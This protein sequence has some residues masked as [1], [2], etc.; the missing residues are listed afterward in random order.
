MGADP[1]ARLQEAYRRGVVNFNDL[2]DAATTK[3]KARALLMKQMDAASAAADTQAADLADAAAR[4]PDTKAALD[5][6][7]RSAAA[8]GEVR[9]SIDSAI[10]QGM[11]PDVISEIAGRSLDTARLGAAT[12]ATAQAA[13]LQ[14]LERSIATNP[15]RESLIKQ[16]NELGGY[17]PPNATDAE[18]ANHAANFI[19]RSKEEEFAVKLLLQRA[20]GAVQA[21]GNVREAEM[22]LAEVFRKDPTIA[23]ADTVRAQYGL[24]TKM[25][26]KPTPTAASD[27][28]AVFGF[29]KMMDPGSVVREGEYERA[30]NATSF[31]DKWG[32][33]AVWDRLS[34]GTLMTPEQR[35]DFIDTV[36]KAA[37]S[38]VTAAENVR[39]R[40]AQQ[41]AGWNLNPENV[42]FDVSLPASRSDSIPSPALAPNE[43]LVAEKNPKTGKRT[44]N[45]AVFVSGPDG[46]LT[47]KKGPTPGVDAPDASFDPRAD[48]IKSGSDIAVRASALP[49]F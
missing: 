26:T 18:V 32:M 4:R 12:Q 19:R 43:V 25:L 20:Q 28:A 15:Q 34:K 31:L 42:V 21:A 30:K 3:P 17:V 6:A 46:T 5:A 45:F 35:K 16:V 8:T 33:T 47:R 38:H 41:A 7:A 24:V 37:Q 48:I 36:T 2:L 39:A 13:K 14:E 11:T 44:G 10:A 29:M 9:A 27:M 22:K 40:V 1:M 23:N 49:G